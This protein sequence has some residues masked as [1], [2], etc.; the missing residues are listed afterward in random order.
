MMLPFI[1]VSIERDVG[2]AELQAYL[3][4]VFTNDPDPSMTTVKP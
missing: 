4:E 1:A 3:E 2:V